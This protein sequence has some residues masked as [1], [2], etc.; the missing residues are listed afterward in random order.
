MK[1]IARCWSIL[2]MM[3]LVA[4][5]LGKPSSAQAANLNKEY[6][7]FTPSYTNLIQKLDYTL[8]GDSIQVKVTIST[9]Y[10]GI[11][12][13]L[14]TIYALCGEDI[15]KESF[16]DEGISTSSFTL[17]KTF[18][19]GE[20]VLLGAYTDITEDTRWTDT[21]DY[22]ELMNNAHIVEMPTLPTDPKERAETWTS[23]DKAVTKTFR[24][25]VNKKFYVKLNI[26][27]DAYLK[28]N[29]FTSSSEVTDH[30]YYVP[31][32]STNEYNDSEVVRNG[33]DIFLKKGTYWLYSRTDGATI[34][35]KMTLR[36]H[37]YSSGVIWTTDGKEITGALSIKKG[38]T[39]AIKATI[40]PSNSDALL[41]TTVLLKN[42]N[43]GYGQIFDEKVSS[44]RKSVTF[45]YLCNDDSGTD[46]ID[47]TVYDIGY[48]ERDYK[49]YELAVGVTP[50]KP[51]FSSSTVFSTH[52]NIELKCHNIF[53]SN[54]TLRVD[55]K[56][57]GKWK[58]VIDEPALKGNSQLH[59][60][61]GLE[62]NTTYTLRTKYYIKV[63]SQQIS[64]GYQTLKVKTGV[65][66]K[67]VIKSLSVSNVKKHKEYSKAYWDN[68]GKYHKGF[69]YYWKSY[70]VKV[71][72][73]KAVPS[74]TLGL[75]LGA[76]KVKGKG[77]TFSF[78]CTTGT[79]SSGYADSATV[80]VSFY[81]DAKYGGVSPSSKARKISLK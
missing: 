24:A 53:D 20:A 31:T 67:P 35:V 63:G 59:Y 43:R 57:G 44:D 6:D 77:K 19:Q 80:A 78:K 56:K 70:T 79:S 51:A 13:S 38:K 30:L 1:Q 72:L 64:S 5:L 34:Q 15:I 71:T 11:G 69:Y 76:A 50:D 45:K 23:K 28:I 10:A 58:K 22:V 40:S 7:N 26:K 61:N 18:K 81:S 29:S 33:D 17:K 39:V 8:V 68:N 73:S 32:S 27:K 3:L 55:M 46:I 12:R 54:V 16:E 66:T 65:K 62:A 47:L 36:H 4:S 2:F 41:P 52:K 9:A 75:K 14:W 42:K 60:V 21:S 49:H 25:V 37:I 48:K 74:G